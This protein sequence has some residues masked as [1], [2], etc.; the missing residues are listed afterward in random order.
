MIDG[1]ASFIHPKYLFTLEITVIGNQ[2]IYLE[3]ALL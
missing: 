2:L 1:W 3:V